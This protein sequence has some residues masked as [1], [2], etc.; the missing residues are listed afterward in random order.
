MNQP[1]IRSIGIIMDGNRRW[2]RE[3]GLPTLE[4]HRRGLDVLRMLSRE[5]PRLKETYGLECVTLFAFSTENWQRTAEEVAYLMRL[6]TQGLEEIIANAAGTARVRIIGERERF[7]PELQEV[8][9]RVE[10]RTAGNSGT[11]VAFAL[12]YGGRAEI[13][14]AAAALAESGVPATE[15][16]FSRALWTAGMPDP[17]LVIRTSGEERL[18]GFLPWQSVYSELFFTDTYWPDFT[19][20]ELE[21]IF[22]EYAAR[23]R[24]HGQ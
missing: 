15:E 14:R 13:L 8:F 24:R 18:S 1:T 11:L 4:G 22:A 12:S 23:E 17:D 9:R 2:A 20:A 16:N 5:L 19:I 7:S 6:F 10:E 3:R 21:N